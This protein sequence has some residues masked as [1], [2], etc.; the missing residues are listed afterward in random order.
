MNT[1]YVY[2]IDDWPTKSIKESQLKVSTHTSSLI[3]T[4]KVP[5]HF[6][7]LGSQP[8]SDLT[9]DKF[10]FYR[11]LKEFVCS[12]QSNNSTIVIVYC[13]KYYI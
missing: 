11:I 9:C 4:W 8:V 6:A 7:N 1:E 2:V 12:R 13:A 10:K 5:L 3:S